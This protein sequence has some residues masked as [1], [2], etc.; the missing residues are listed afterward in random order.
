MHLICCAKRWVDYNITTVDMEGRGLILYFICA[1]FKA[2]DLS[3]QCL[4]N[5][6]PP[7]ITVNRIPSREVEM[8][9]VL[10]PHQLLLMVAVSPPSLPE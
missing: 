1:V 8:K 9:R 7:L 5:C 6:A 2:Q 10:N 3:Q 4:T